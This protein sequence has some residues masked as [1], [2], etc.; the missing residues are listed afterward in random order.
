MTK[1][2]GVGVLE[3]NNLGLLLA[4]T[5]TFYTS[6]AKEIKLKVRKFCGLSPTFVE[7]TGEKLVRTFLF[8]YIDRLIPTWR[9]V[10]L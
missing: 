4:M 2:G 6:V 8:L 7:V 1:G 3:F 10:C 5:L 9:K